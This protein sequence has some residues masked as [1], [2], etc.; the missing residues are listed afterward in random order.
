MT[1]KRS[2]IA[3]PSTQ[4]LACASEGGCATMNASAMIWPV[5]FWHG[6]N[7][8]PAVARGQGDRFFRKA[9]ALRRASGARGPFECRWWWFG[10]GVVERLDIGASARSFS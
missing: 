10:S 4:D 3:H 6:A 7:Q 1:L 9:S 2:P 5:A 8:R